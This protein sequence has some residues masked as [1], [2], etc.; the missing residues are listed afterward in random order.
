MSG[1]AVKWTS[2]ANQ[3]KFAGRVYVS[4][5]LG[6]ANQDSFVRLGEIPLKILKSRR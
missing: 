5:S 6:A 3:Q 4:F 2:S 1:I